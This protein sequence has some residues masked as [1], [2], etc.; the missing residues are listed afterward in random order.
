MKY[1]RIALLAP[2]ALFVAGCP[3]FPVTDTDPN[4][5]LARD[6]HGTYLKS[7]LGFGVDS[8]RPLFYDSF[9]EQGV[10]VAPTKWQTV[11]PGSASGGDTWKTSATQTNFG[12]RS[13]TYGARDIIEQAAE[14]GKVTLTTKDAISLA[15]AADPVLVFFAGFLQTGQD[16]DVT[17]FGVEVSPDLGFNWTA[18]VPTGAA[19]G[20]IADPTVKPGGGT[21]WRRF[22]F[23]LAPYKGQSVRLR[24]SLNATAN[25]RKLVYI[26]DVLVADAK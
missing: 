23:S 1:H 7:E 14:P 22:R 24:L 11:Q 25:S 13:L 17:A 6:L 16:S 8:S 21:I 10:G 19:T 2:I 18:L 26:D 5:Q 15:V 3:A 12:T 20:S 9:E 4:P